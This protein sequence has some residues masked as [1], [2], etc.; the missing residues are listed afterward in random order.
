MQTDPDIPDY[1]YSDPTEKLIFL[2][3]DHDINR[4]VMIFVPATYYL[5]FILSLFGNGLIL[6]VL[7]KYEHLKTVTNIF[8]LNLVLSDLLFTTSLPFWAVTEWIF[9]SALCRIMTGIYFTGLNSYIIFLMLMTVDRYLAIVHTISTANARKVRYAVLLSVIVW[10]VSALAAV[11]ESVYSEITFGD[12]VIQCKDMDHQSDSAE[13][14]N[15]MGIYLNIM[16]SFI[17]P[18]VIVLYCYSRIIVK[19][20]RSNIIE[21][22]KAV[23]HIFFLMVT[24]FVSYAPYS[25]FIFVM[26]IQQ[27]EVATEVSCDYT[28]HYIYYIFRTI[29]YLHCCINPIFYTFLGTKFRQH[30]LTLFKNC[31]VFILPC[32]R[33]VFRNQTIGSNHQSMNY[34]V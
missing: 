16:L 23:K 18:F 6:L 34:V 7:L 28:L 15:H 5:I 27:P 9:G 14:W 32:C 26:S 12:G 33:Q 31:F 21:K 20:I 24:F 3:D 29:A 2:C 13:V 4:F 11:P 8:I 22:H 30:L 10:T 17:M 1:A 19:I 25:I